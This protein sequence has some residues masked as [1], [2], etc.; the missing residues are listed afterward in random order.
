METDNQLI[1]QRIDKI[2]DMRK[3]GINPYPYKFDKKN[4]SLDIIENF[5]KLKKEEKADTKVSI[6]GRIVSSRIM[7]KASFI[8]IQDE[9]GKIQIYVRKD[10]VREDS[11]N[12]F[13]KLQI[14]YF[15]IKLFGFFVFPTS[16]KRCL[17]I[18]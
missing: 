18:R 13:K 6:A 16:A 14:N 10:D 8:D 17:P 7:G 12:L 2:D 3:R 15:Y 1:K 11:Y 5:S 9:K 4:S